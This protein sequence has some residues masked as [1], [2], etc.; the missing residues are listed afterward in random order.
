VGLGG[1]EVRTV[2]R[3]IIYAEKGSGLFL[4]FQRSVM[5]P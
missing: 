3:E 2:G 1:G 4:F 5:K